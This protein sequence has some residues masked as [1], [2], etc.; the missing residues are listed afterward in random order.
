MCLVCSFIAKFDSRRFAAAGKGGVAIAE[1]KGLRILE[2][3]SA[4]GQ[5]A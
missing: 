1:T 3:L 5:S 4:T 2:G